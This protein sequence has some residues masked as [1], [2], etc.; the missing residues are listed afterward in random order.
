MCEILLCSSLVGLLSGLSSNCSTAFRRLAVWLHIFSFVEHLQKMFIPFFYTKY[1]P[2]SKKANSAAL[3]CVAPIQLV[4]VGLVVAFFYFVRPPRVITILVANSYT[5]SLCT[6]TKLC[7]LLC[8]HA[9]TMSSMPI[10]LLLINNQQIYR[11]FDYPGIV[12]YF[13]K[14]ARAEILEAAGR[15]SSDDGGAL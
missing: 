14:V 2:T 9:N 10:G 7:F 1:K 11:G 4:C 15:H 8:M 6:Q 3:L 12:S 5:Q 13:F